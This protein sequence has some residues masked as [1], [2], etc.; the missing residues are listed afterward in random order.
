MKNSIVAVSL[1]LRFASLAGTPRLRI[2]TILKKKAFFFLFIFLKLRKENMI[3]LNLWR[4]WYFWDVFEK[5]KFFENIEIFHF[6]ENFEI[7]NFLRLLRFL[8][9]L[10]IWWCYCWCCWCCWC[11]FVVVECLCWHFSKLGGAGAVTSTIWSVR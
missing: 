4:F 8:M 6:F 7:L 1:T 3:F 11:C 10:M 2:F 9:I 5:F